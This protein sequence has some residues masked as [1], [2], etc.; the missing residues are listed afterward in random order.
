MIVEMDTVGDHHFV[1]IL[2]DFMLR[3]GM[4]IHHCGVG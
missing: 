2:K 1:G 3:S 4:N